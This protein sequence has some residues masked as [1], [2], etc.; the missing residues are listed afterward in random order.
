MQQNSVKIART[1]SKEILDGNIKSIMRVILA[2]AAHFKPSN[3]QS[4]PSVS[5]H[6]SSAANRHS[7]ASLTRPVSTCSLNNLNKPTN[8]NTNNILTQQNSKHN[9]N[10]SRN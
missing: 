9:L 1:T 2:L 7:A 10:S 3:L 5:T 6:S 8:S 4:A